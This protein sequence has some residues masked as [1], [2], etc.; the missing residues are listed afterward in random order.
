MDHRIA[1]KPNT[2]LCLYNDRGEAIHCVIKNEIGRGGSSIVYEASRLAETGD[3]TLYRIKEFYP[4]QLNITRDENG[5]LIPS[6]QD[7]KVFERR[8][9]QFRSDFSRT[10][11]LF[12]SDI[13]YSAMTN[14]LDV[15][16][17]NGTSYILSAYSSRKTLASDQPKTLKECI[18]LVKQ[19]AYVLGN[20]HKHGYLYLDI[21]PDNVLVVDGYQK[22][23][24]LFDFD[25]L[26]DIQ[27]V[28]KI[29]RVG[30]GHQRLSY[31][32]GFAPVE[33]QTSKIKR[34]GPHTDIYGIGALLFYLLFGDT[35]TAP[36][37]ERDAVFDFTKIKY[38]HNRC[39][40]R[41]FG[42][43]EDFFHKTL[44]VYYADRT[45][46]MQEVLD[47]LETIERYAD[48]L[49]PRIFSTPIIRPGIFYGR[50]HELEALDRHLACLDG[51]GLF[52]TGMGGIGKSTLIREY[53]IRRRDSFD[54]ILY[55]HFQDSIETT[56]SNDRNIEIN[57]LRQDEEAQNGSRYFEKKLQKIREL[58]RGTSS[59]L[60][61]DHFTGELDDDLKALLSTDLKVILLSRRAPA[62]QG[63]H[64]MKLAAIS[65]YKALCHIFEENLGRRIKD[66][67]KEAFGQILNCIQGH[68]L[69]LE[70]IA[71]QIAN[72]HITISSASDLTQTY[73]F[74]AI[75]PEKVDYEKDSNLI[76]DTIGNI[77]DALFETNMLSEEKQTLMKVASLLGD[78]GI[79]INLFQRIMKLVSKD[80]LNE[81][82]Q[83]GWLII[84]GDRITMH[85]VI[86]E[87]LHR[88]QWAPKML[89]AAKQFLT[90]FFV[91]IRLESTKNNYPKRLL[92]NL[93]VDGTEKTPV[94]K[95]IR[96]KWTAV[97]YHFMKRNDKQP[98]LSKDE[99]KLIERV[100]R[101]RFAR[102][103]DES[104]ADIEKLTGLLFQAEQ[105][106][107]QC[108]R[109]SVILDTDL[110]SNLQLTVLLN[111]P[112]YRE[113]FIF[114]E[115]GRV[116]A[117]KV[118][119]IDFKD[120]LNSE[121][122]IKKEAVSM[123]KVYELVFS[124]YAEHEDVKGM[125]GVLSHAYDTMKFF[126][127]HNAY[128]IYYDLVSEYYDILLDGCYDAE[129]S[130][131]VYLL[132]ELLDAIDLTL[133]YSK[134]GLWHD[135]KHLYVK[136]ILAK[137]TI[138]MRSVR[139][140]EEE[141][142]DL[143]TIAKEIILENTSSYA[144]VRLHYHLVCAWYFALIRD[145]ESDAETFIQDALELSEIIIPTDLEKIES[146]IIPCANIFF[147]LGC[148]RRSMALLMEGIDLCAQHMN[149]DA[150]VQIRQDLYNH[151]W[152]VGIDGQQFEA[153]VKMIKRMMRENKAILNP[154]NRVV[155]PEEIDRII[156]DYR[157]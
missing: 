37:C 47:Q 140:T 141:I 120:T 82:I 146:V 18:V 89:C 133:H 149:A 150:Y 103:H 42:A 96:G 45:H 155:M 147:E 5:R 31:S 90:Y 134:N 126:Q 115:A 117:E 145:S 105:I 104:P 127:D 100:D 131:D 151:F 99:Q 53:L 28:Q 11:Q 75:A 80:D 113:D 36:D 110:F 62:Y 93:A 65:D 135:E 16:R 157:L 55:V 46:N 3:E 24:Q 72:S 73:G 97:R 12:Y 13:N 35:P 156:K 123:M 68:T 58:V 39:D 2:P 32:K 50:K 122:D 144:D 139:G 137:A 21:K 136:N 30:D 154:E 116:L 70:L 27:E 60:V 128:A 114:S 124:I 86:W 43:L 61:I 132:K 87:A 64:E 29:G 78:D 23:V 94:L 33:L 112:R 51:R 25:S 77:I 54:T 85:R 10:N 118:K 26:L 56:I 48:L 34:L 92:K 138:L 148:H 108:Q 91:E 111:M 84:S 20:L 38:D 71:K 6:P 1:L 76:R 8:Q 98:K 153:C 57:T 49:I 106:I 40:D 22:Q 107:K 102:I 7:A 152:E 101:E 19:V 17:Q 59:V 67:E 129:T 119:A 79:E 69:V 14:Q 4:Y 95:R 143:I 74:S 142:S 41:L 15:F 63:G 125:E 130:E 83:D 81:L 121:N 66:H 52:I 44:A 9:A 88:W 109:E